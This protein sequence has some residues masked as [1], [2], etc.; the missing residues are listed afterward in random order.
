M[1][2]TLEQAEFIEP[3]IIIR[4]DIASPQVQNVVELLNG[5]QSLKKIFLHR[6]EKEYL[7]DITDVVYFEAENNKIF[8]HVGEE[9]FETR[10]KLYELESIGYT[11]GFI[12][13]SKGV[14]VNIQHVLSVEAEFSGN[15]TLHLKKLQT[16]LILSRKY[17]NRFKQYIMEVY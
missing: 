5:K 15:Y 3:E 12:R 10:H 17:V 1:K 11:K 7:F 16:H 9:I 2:I 8:A 4:G 14:I 6:Q 13:I